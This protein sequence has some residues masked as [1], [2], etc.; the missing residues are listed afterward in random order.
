LDW[1]EGN[2]VA[3]NWIVGGEAEGRQ[4]FGCTWCVKKSFWKVFWIT[5]GVV[6]GSRDTKSLGSFA[7]FEIDPPMGVKF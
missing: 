6:D 1:A 5:S 7:C 3:A 2:H 4:F